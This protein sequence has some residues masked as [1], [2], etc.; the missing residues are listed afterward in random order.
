[1]GGLILGPAHASSQLHHHVALRR[2]LYFLLGDLL[3]RLIYLSFALAV[4]PAF[5]GVKLILPALHARS[6]GG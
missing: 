5:V 4:L 2:Q 3:E 1:V 6:R